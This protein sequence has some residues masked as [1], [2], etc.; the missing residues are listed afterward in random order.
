MRPM[1]GMVGLVSSNFKVL[2][3]HTCCNVAIA[4]SRRFAPTI[5]CVNSAELF[6][7][8]MKLL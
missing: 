7:I 8:L 2:I 4:P 6:L 5:V 1:P 3:L